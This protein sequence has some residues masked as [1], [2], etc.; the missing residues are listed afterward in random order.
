VDSAH[1]HW[2]DYRDPQWGGAVPLGTSRNR[3]LRVNILGGRLYYVSCVG[4]RSTARRVRQDAALRLI[5]ATLDAHALPD[6][7]LVLSLSDRPTVPRSAVAAQ[8]PPHG[9]PLVFAYVQ[10]PRH[11]SV[12]F[13][14]ATFDPRRWTPLFRRLG[15]HPPLASRKQ[16]AVWRGS[17]NSLCDML[18]DGRGAC[19]PEMLDRLRLLQHASRCPDLADVALTKP[20]GNCRGFPA[21]AAVSMAAHAEYAF[22]VHAD[23]NGFSGRA[24][25]GARTFDGLPLTFH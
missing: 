20:H 19:T 7:D 22:L 2:A 3:L 15:E 6:V 4:Q 18:K 23:G 21:R 25:R 9:V 24:R 16:R 5:Q 8:P 10:T 17:C 14:Y 12:P 1:L 11:W 13:P